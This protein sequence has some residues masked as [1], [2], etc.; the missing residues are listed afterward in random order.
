M[1][2]SLFPENDEPALLNEINTTPL[3]DVMLVLLIML[4][5]TIP[6]QTHTVEV[7]SPVAS[8]SKATKPVIW[9]IDID[10]QGRIL[11]NGQGLGG[12]A[13]LEEHLRQA[14]TDPSHPELHL[15]PSRK[16]PY[17]SVAAV[18]AA[19]QRVGVNRLGLVGS[20]QFLP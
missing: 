1:P 4:I 14:N 8:A 7:D 9:T 15:R 3:I 5:I 12:V 18:L 20:E 17:R 6:I 16:A 10:D 13:D 11:W 2:P 19:G